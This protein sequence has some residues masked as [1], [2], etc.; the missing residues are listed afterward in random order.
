[1]LACDPNKG[2]FACVRKLIDEEDKDIG[3]LAAKGRLGERLKACQKAF[4][5][6]KH[7]WGDI[8]NWEVFLDLLILD[9][10]ELQLCYK[11]LMKGHLEYASR[12]PSSC[13]SC[14]ALTMNHNECKPTIK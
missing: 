12:L 13:S 3:T 11:C 1:M 8:S 10:R 6:T 9:K 2:K 7:Q 4:K 5:A 14:E